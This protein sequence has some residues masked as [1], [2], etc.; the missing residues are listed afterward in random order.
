MA[1]DSSRG[2][3]RDEAAEVEEGDKSEGSEDPERLWLLREV[4]M[5]KRPAMGDRGALE[6]T[7]ESRATRWSARHQ[8]QYAMLQPWRGGGG[9]GGGE[10]GEDESGRSTALIRI[11]VSPTSL[12]AR[13]DSQCPARSGR[14][15]WWIAALCFCASALSQA[16]NT[17]LAPPAGDAGQR[18]STAAASSAGDARVVLRRVEHSEPLFSSTVAPAPARDCSRA[19]S[20][21]SHAHGAQMQRPHAESHRVVNRSHAGLSAAWARDG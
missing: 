19:V 5:G 18:S 2:H 8:I 14:P 15:T 13:R 3:E 16:R 10:E 21:T 11:G 7:G 20:V 12:L 4:L 1:G 6:S 9:R 17:Q